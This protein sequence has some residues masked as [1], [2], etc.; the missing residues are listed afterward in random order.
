[1][2]A[3]DGD[4]PPLADKVATMSRFD[5]LP[6]VVRCAISGAAFQFHPQAAEKKLARGI[7]G[8]RC[9]EILQ[10]ND[11]RITARLRGVE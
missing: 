3:T 6:S 8:P 9:A 4:V 10:E 11:A 2:D 5:A 7:L 1:M